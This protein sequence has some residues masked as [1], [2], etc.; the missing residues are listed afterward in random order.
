L[1]EM[2]RQGTVRIWRPCFEKSDQ[3]LGG[4]APETIFWFLRRF[5]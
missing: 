5:L 2:A 4:R 3:A 1:E